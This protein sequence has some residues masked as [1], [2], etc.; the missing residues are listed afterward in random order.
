MPS[1]AELKRAART[2]LEWLW[3]WYWTQL[4]HAFGL[5]PSLPTFD[6]GTETS[7]TDRLHNI[8]KTYVKAR[9]QEIKSKRRSDLCTSA[10]TAWSTYTLRFT[11]GGT[12][13]PPAATQ[14]KLLE[15]LVTDPASILP[16]DK[17][18]GSTMS[19]AFLVW[20]LFLRLFCANSPTFFPAL[21]ALVVKEIN[22]RAR[23]E[24]HREG[25]CEWAVH[26]L[27]SR[28]WREARGNAAR[29]MREKVLGECMT[30]LGTWNLRLAEGI[31]AALDDGEKDMWS[32][33][34]DASRTGSG[35]S[36]VA[37]VAAKSETKDTEDEME[38]DLQAEEESV[39]EA[40][41]AGKEGETK[42]LTMVEVKEKI[43]GPQKV[44]GLWKPKP[45]GWLPDGWDED[46]Q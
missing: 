27:A 39:A 9:K 25:L 12:T 44:V 43:R 22:E 5:A 4:D 20:S 41:P 23:C 38:V 2:A 18:L 37:D 14:N 19:G 29:S 16:Q 26:M 33:I 45:I 24:E 13:L 17:K 36:I 21:L 15:L 7:V 10:A 46:A 34:L 40:V 30:E 32:A 35:G 31:V 3:E 28:E 11:P 6:M 8:I 42:A 1:L